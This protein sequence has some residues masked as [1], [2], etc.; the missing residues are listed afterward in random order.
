MYNKAQLDAIEHFKGPCM[1]LAGP[2][3]GKTTVITKRT[4]YL[5]DTYGVNPS[6][7]LVVTFT[8][9]AAT[10]MKE[11]YERIIG[12]STRVVFATFHSLF[13]T[14][15]KH[16]Y[17]YSAKDVISPERQR[18]IISN[19]IFFNKLEIEDEND[20]ISQIL[21]EISRVKTEKN[22][23][24]TY[25]ALSC[26]VLV[27]RDIYR[28]YCKNLDKEK[29][30][31]FD[32]MMLYCHQLFNERKDI[33]RKWQE[34]YQYILIDEFQDI[35]RLQ[36][37]IMKLLAMP[38]NNIFIVGD[39]DQ[40][41]YGFRGSD[42]TIMLGFEK[43][44]EGAR[45]ILLDVNYRSTPNI[46][47]AATRLIENNKERFEKDIKAFAKKGM[48]VRIEEFED[49][50]AENEKIV[51]E[52]KAYIANDYKY[53]DIAILFRTNAVGR[54]LLEKFFEHNIPFRS[55]DVIPNIY[56]HFVAKHLITYIKVAL[57]DYS[58]KNIL[59][60]IN[61]PSRY[62]TKDCLDEEIINFERL[63]TYYEDK[64]YVLDRIDKFEYD[65]KL[66]RD[67]NPFTAINYIRRA[68][69]YDEYLQEYAK[70]R[71]ID[72]EELLD[73]INEIQENAKL[74]ITFDLWFEHIAEYI[75]KTKNEF[76]TSNEQDA[77]T[78]STMHSSK[79]LEYKVVYIIDANE[80]ITPYKKALLDKEL[81]EERRMFYVAM[82]RAKEELHIMSTKKKNAKNL[83]I[84][85]F[86]SEIALQNDDDMI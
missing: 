18:S 42:T 1:V 63:R 54:R 86:I 44:Y 28:F 51:E 30:I 60:I 6:N 53:N 71:K 50:N 78:F 27:F 8:K 7:I 84:S 14:I 33:L 45:K 26:P 67:L 24:D 79:G 66:I 52:V 16:A 37:D 25:N 10:E 46:V 64:D 75:E 69:G 83:Q 62:I 80:G 13:F 32:D 76:A 58:R 59:E 15:I 70:Y 47:E 74:Y 82:T 29:L 31:D 20:F 9:A 55:R 41:I 21:S 72:Y 77:V 43:D 12:G 68:V 23:I 81:E 38:Q 36:Y 19:Y 57:G 73:I 22:P 48:P 61:K 40:S 5:T 49:A 85:R 17:N 11:R 4:Q 56:E 34:K 3:S 35:N 65:L 2:G 39:D